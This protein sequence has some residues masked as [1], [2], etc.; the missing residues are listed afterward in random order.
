MENKFSLNIIHS[1]TEANINFYAS[2][3]VHPKRTMSQHDFIYMLDGEW[4][5]GQ[6][7]EVYNIKKD[8]LL[9]LGANNMHYGISPCAPKTKTM[10]FHVKSEAKDL[11][12]PDLSLPSLFT[13]PGK[14]VKKVFSEI[15]RAI[16]SGNK[17]KANLYFELLLL[18]LD[19]TKRH[20]G[21]VEVAA[22]IKNLI[23]DNPEVFFSNEELAQAANV[24]VKTAENKFKA[25]YGK[26]IHAYILDFKIKEA[27]TTFE[28]FPEMSIKEIAYNLGFYDEYHFSKQFKKITGKSPSEYKRRQNKKYIR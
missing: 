22:K 18:E 15:V 25:A 20:I 8:D 1:V 14:N 11:D 7:G 2:P 21:A 6:N 13:S 28:V 23:H 12:I 5:L 19:E 3:F 17:R 10:Y 16:L 9:I 26:T 4:Q 24:S 27:I